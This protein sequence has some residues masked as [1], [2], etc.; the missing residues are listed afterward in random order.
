MVTTNKSDGIYVGGPGSAAS[1][2]TST[3]NTISSNTVNFNH[4]NGINA[5]T[6]SATNTFTGNTAN[7]NL[8]Y[9]LKDA[10]SSNTWMSNTCRPAHDSNPAGLC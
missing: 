7:Y 1:A 2:T 8:L 6:S 9:D 3:G 5:D 10:G 4:G